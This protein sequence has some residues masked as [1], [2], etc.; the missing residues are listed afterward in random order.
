MC[1]ETRNTQCS[2]PAVFSGVKIPRHAMMLDITIY[3]E[4]STN[5]KYKK[6]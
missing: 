6:I 4:V 3:D 2:T 5:F 1:M